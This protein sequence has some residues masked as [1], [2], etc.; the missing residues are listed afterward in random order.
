MA[1]RKPFA[2]RSFVA[3]LLLLAACSSKADDGANTAPAAQSGVASYCKAACAQAA[4][5]NPDL[6]GS[7]CASDCESNDGS[8]SLRLLRAD[9]MAA[10]QQCAASLDC[11]S[12]PNTAQWQGA[13]AQCRDD[14]FSATVPSD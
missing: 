6:A 3:C 13:L 14:A 7:K 5:C 11:A 9:T 4:S 2:T 10:F 1:T 12:I 8:R